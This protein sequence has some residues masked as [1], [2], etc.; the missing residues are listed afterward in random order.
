MNIDW[1]EVAKERRMNTLEERAAVVSADLGEWEIEWRYIDDAK[2]FFEKLSYS[3]DQFGFGRFQYILIPKKKELKVWR[4]ITHLIGRI[5][6]TMSDSFP[7][8]ATDLIEYPEGAKL[9]T[10]EQVGKV[11]GI[12]RR[13]RSLLTSV[14]NNTIEIEIADEALKIFK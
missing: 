8:C 10:R 9:L 1:N 13:Y 14:D 7:I 6:P 5:T 3:P 11:E 12:L 2:S 4:G